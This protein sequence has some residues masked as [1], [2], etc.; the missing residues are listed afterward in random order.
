M[1]DFNGTIP[2]NATDAMFNITSAP[3][4]APTSTEDLPC[5][6]AINIPCDSA[7][8]DGD[9]SKEA[10]WMILWTVSLIAFVCLPFCISQSRRELCWRRI[11]ERRWISDDRE[12]DWYTA[13]VR[14]QQEQRRQHVEEEQRRFRTSRNQEDEIREQYLMQC[15]ENFTMVRTCM[16]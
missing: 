12:D 10:L 11:K 5:F 7:T 1:E 6:I 2:D 9:M 8:A 13:A 15:M 16:E 14:R 4:F 3:S